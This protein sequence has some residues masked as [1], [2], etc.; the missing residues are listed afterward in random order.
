MYVDSQIQSQ[1][2]YCSKQMYL[3]KYRYFVELVYCTRY[4]IISI[5]DTSTVVLWNALGRTTSLLPGTCTIH[6]KHRREIG[7]CTYVIHS[8]QDHSAAG[9]DH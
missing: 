2:Q 9:L 5:N 3:Y 6:D 7:T 8:R 4:L 1:M